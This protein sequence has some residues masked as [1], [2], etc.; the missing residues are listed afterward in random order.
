[1]EIVLIRHS[2]AEGNLR[3][4]FLGRTDDPLAACGVELARKRRNELPMVERVYHSPMLRALC[5]ARLIW[6]DAPKSAVQGLREMD[7][8]LFDGRTND[9]LMEDETYRAWLAQGEWAGYP[10]GES[11]AEAD[12]RCAAAFRFLVRD[13]GERGL[14][15][16]G[17][18]VHGGTL[19]HLMRR[20]TEAE[21][22]F[23][24]LLVKNC[25]G[26]LLEAHYAKK[27]VAVS[28]WERI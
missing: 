9:E 26:F 25:E 12:A 28:R 5:T 23:T 24:D 13:A 7:F 14:T 2:I 8:G 20:Y 18:V 3:R 1:M 4:V 6:P 22:N 21:V 17:A 27:E 10:K 15:R 16:V 19:M 11:F